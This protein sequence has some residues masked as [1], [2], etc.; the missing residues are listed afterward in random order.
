MYGSNNARV[1]AV[2]IASVEYP[3]MKGSIIYGFIIVLLLL[4]L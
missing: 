3:S 2:I 4:L 1:I